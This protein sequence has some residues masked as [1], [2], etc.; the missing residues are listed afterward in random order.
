MLHADAS[1]SQV[2]VTNTNQWGLCKV[3]TADVFEVRAKGEVAS[4]WKDSIG[5]SFMGDLNTECQSP[6]AL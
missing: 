2:I 5:W 6:S 3:S 1:P 4:E